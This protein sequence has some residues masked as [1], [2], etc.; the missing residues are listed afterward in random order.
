MGSTLQ[1]ALFV[2]PV[3]VLVG[4]FIG[5]PLDLFFSLFELAAIGVTMLIINN[6]TQDG[7]SNWFEGLQLLA[8]YA[9]LAVAFFFHP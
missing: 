3:L 4:F 2:A 5:K 7:E 6:I 8:L 1:V 9:I